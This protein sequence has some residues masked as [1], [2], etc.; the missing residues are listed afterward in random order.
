[1]KDYK[2]IMKL[3]SFFTKILDFIYYKKCYLCSK[4]CIDISLCEECLEKIEEKL[5]FHHAKKF[6]TEIYSG[7]TYEGELLKIIR[8]LKYHKKRE[9]EK[10]LTD[11]LIKTVEH[12]NLDLSSFVVCPVPIHENRFKKRKYNHMELV[13]NEFAKHFDLEVNSDLLKRQKDTPPLYSLSFSERKTQ[14][15]GAFIASNE[16]KA[17]KILL[18]DDIVTSGTTICELSKIIREKEPSA[19]VAIC[20]TRSNS[21]NF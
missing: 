15:N 14:I 17:K 6:G 1:M 11:I 5:N 16:I 9:F 12:Y 8:A 10:V 4:K 20:A 2:I 19:F 18:L 21:C 13:A 7:S 3:I